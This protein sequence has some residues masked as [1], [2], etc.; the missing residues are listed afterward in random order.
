MENDVDLNAEYY[1]KHSNLQY[2]IASE[3]IESYHFSKDSLVLDV[4]CGD[5]RITAEIAK[6]IANGKIVGIDASPNMIECA[7]KSFPKQRYPNLVFQLK[8]VENLVFS[9]SFDT[10][11]S[12]SCFHWVR[13]PEK[14]LTLL[15]DFLK[16][17]GNLLILAYPKE[18]LFYS[19]MQS[20]LNKY[21]DFFNL[22][23]YITMLSIDEYRNILMNNGLDV[24]EVISHK[25][26]A[27]YKDEEAVK[28]FIRGWL[29]SFVPLPPHLHE[30]FLDEVIKESIP[31][32]IDL[33]D[34]LI[35]LPYTAMII[36]AAK[37]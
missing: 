15:C 33:Q 17:K 35:N 12:F 37:K 5:G 20:A 21:P 32:R 4:G 9:E 24:H 26:V 11:V 29:S 3:L 10:I 13:E 14:A 6:K 1:V 16:Q 23:A 36:K 7:R 22:S 31:Y 27:S 2:G 8:K 34:G 30:V 25:L 18:S 28:Q 19:F